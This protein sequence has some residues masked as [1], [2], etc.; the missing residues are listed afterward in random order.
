MPQVINGQALNNTE[1]FDKITSTDK[2]TTGYFTGGVGKLVA[3][4]LIS[5]SL[6]ST[7][8]DYYTGIAK[9][10][11][12]GSVQFHVAYGNVNGYGSDTDAGAI[13]GQTEAIYKEWAN[14]LLAPTE[15]TGGFKIS[16]AGT[17]N[18]AG[19]K[20]EGIYVLV[21]QRSLFKDRINKKN[22]TVYLSGSNTANTRGDL[23]KLILTDDSKNVAATSTPAGPRYNIVSGSDGTPVQNATART[24]GW[25]YPDQGVLVFSQAELSAS[26]PG[27]GSQ[28]GSVVQYDKS[29]FRGFGA[30]TSVDQNY[31][32]SLRFI[33]CAKGGN[34]GYL[35]FRAEEDQTAVSYFCRARAA[36][37]NFS[38]NPTF[39]S[40]SQNELRQES[41]KGNPTSYV[42]GCELYDTNGTMVATGKL[43]TPLKK[44]FSS[45]ATI[46]V[47]LTF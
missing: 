1:G 3:S 23:T 30:G 45:E 14:I 40:G 12:T 7:Q 16:Q 38:N 11:I 36:H 8:E 31:R 26:I 13:K 6:Q 33:N 47:K 17:N 39:V 29:S 42:T 4:Q 10:T 25:F 35:K 15:V 32:E 21:G 43:S 24:Y 46:K 9:D 18:A 34:A 44:N 20:D 5:A 37:F 2:I 27:S 41:M 19:G 22:W 28:L